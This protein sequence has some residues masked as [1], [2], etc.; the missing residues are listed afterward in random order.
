VQVEDMK[1]VATVA[2][3]FVWQTAT[4]DQLLPRKK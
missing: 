1:Q 2:A 4:R 3:V